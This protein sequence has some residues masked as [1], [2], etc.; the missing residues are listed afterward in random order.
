MPKLV[1]VSWQERVRRLRTFGFSGPYPGGKHLFI[2]NETLRLTIPNPHKREV[3]VDLLVRLLKQANI[4]K[5]E[6]LRKS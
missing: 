4:T 3:G 2:I 1:P 6:W 5:D